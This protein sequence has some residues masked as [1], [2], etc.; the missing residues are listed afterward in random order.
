MKIN[1]EYLVSPNFERTFKI[2]TRTIIGALSCSLLSSLLVLNNNLASRNY[3]HPIHPEYVN[4]LKSREYVNP[5]EEVFRMRRNGNYQAGVII[6]AY[7]TQLMKE[8][9]PK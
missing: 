5:V 4:A 7:K 8:L 9:S 6:D 2:A 1:R 3:E